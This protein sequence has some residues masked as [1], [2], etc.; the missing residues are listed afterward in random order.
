METV[1]IK[2]LFLVLILFSAVA[3]MLI[4]PEY[5]WISLITATQPANAVQQS[6]STLHRNTQLNSFGNLNASSNSNQFNIR[7]NVNPFPNLPSPGS[8]SPSTS[9]LSQNQ[10]PYQYPYSYGYQ[11]QPSSALPVTPQGSSQLQSQNQYPNPYQQ[12]QQVQQPQPQPLQTFP[13]P[14]ST[15]QPQQPTQIQPSTLP[16]VSY[17]S[18]Y[19]PQQPQQQNQSSS[20]QTNTSQSPYQPQQPHSSQSFTRGQPSVS[21]LI[22]VTHVND[23]GR[24]SNAANAAD[25]FTQIVENTYTNPDGYTNVYHYMKGSQIGVTL[26]LQPGGFSVYELNKNIKSS[27]LPLN[28]STY[29]ITYSGDCRTVKSNTGGTTYGYGTINLGETKTCTVALSLY[30]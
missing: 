11:N 22:I 18:Q 23:T 12:G 8:S 2:K 14:P 24:I 3:A 1:S 26:S 27:N 29:D 28:Q 6:S 19:Q 30:K 16:S 7:S 17:P 9:S 5:S 25:N 10:Y 4:W 21:T 13:P 15:V 20:L